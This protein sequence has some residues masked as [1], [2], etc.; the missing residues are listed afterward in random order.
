MTKNQYKQSKLPKL[1]F[2]QTE[3]N[4]PDGLVSQLVHPVD[5]RFQ[6]I[7]EPSL[8]SQESNKT[9]GV[10]FQLRMTKN[11][12]KQTKYPNKSLQ[13]TK[14]KKS[15]KETGEAY[16]FRTCRIHGYPPPHFSLLSFLLPSKSSLFSVNESGQE[17][18]GTK[19]HPPSPR[20]MLGKKKKKTPC[21]FF[22]SCLYI[23]NPTSASK[24]TLFL[25][26]STLESAPSTWDTHPPLT[27]LHS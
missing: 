13:A 11:Q 23:I 20:K 5:K 24:P 9:N 12:H 27:L 4:E 22:H 2:Q 15:I 10:Q 26:L 16:N 17:D 8:Q 25:T 18:P 7:S 6:K 14:A 3:P 19:Y 21:F 1:P